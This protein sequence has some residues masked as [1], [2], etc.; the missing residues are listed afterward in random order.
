MKLAIIIEGV[1]NSGKTSTILH[2]VNQHQSRTLTVMRSGLKSLYLNPSFQALRVE[3]YIISS[4]PSESDTP[5]SKRF[6]GLAVLP[7]LIII[8]EQ[9]G[10]RHQANTIT[11]L[12]TNGYSIVT[13]PITNVIGSLDWQRFDTSNKAIKL[14]NRANEIMDSIKSFIKINS[15][16]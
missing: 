4:S 7:E 8:A 2:F 14:T 10:G 6:S 16:I 13:F 15:I 1:Q 5:L 9:T 12:T 11:F 3:P